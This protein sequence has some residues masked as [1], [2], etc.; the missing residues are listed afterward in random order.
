MAKV[1][2][3]VVELPNHEDLVDEHLNK[4]E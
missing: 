2:I 3:T 4:E 1:K